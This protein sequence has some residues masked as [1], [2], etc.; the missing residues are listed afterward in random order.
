MWHYVNRGNRG[1]CIPE[2]AMDNYALAYGSFLIQR[3]KESYSYH[4]W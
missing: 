4:E 2:L 3:S 1:R